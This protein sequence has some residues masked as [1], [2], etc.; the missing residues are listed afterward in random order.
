MSRRNASRGSSNRQWNAYSPPD[1]SGNA[2]ASGSRG[3]PSF[4]YYNPEGSSQSQWWYNTFAEGQ[5]QPHS[6]PPPPVQYHNPYPF[7]SGSN[8][9][10]NY[11]EY[12]PMETVAFQPPPRA[13]SRTVTPPPTQSPSPDYLATSDESSAPISDPSSSR[14]LLILDLNGTLLHRSPHVPKGRVKKPEEHVVPQNPPLPRLRPVHPRPYMPSFRSYVFHPQTKAWLD[15]MIWSSAQ[16][17]SVTDMV[18]KCFGDQKD[19]LAAVWA[20][21]TLGLATEHYCTIFPWLSISLD[22]IK[23]GSVLVLRSQSADNERSEYTLEQ[24]V[25][26]AACGWRAGVE[27]AFSQDY[28]SDG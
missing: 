25:R 17:H 2:G 4:F 10:D 5:E 12:R 13:R 8:Y 16:P 23:C 26:R 18:H 14:K 21:D 15:V 7:Y 1:S 19:Q 6:E 9:Y 24:A 11:Q 27:Y 28:A 3:Q 20:R 22:S